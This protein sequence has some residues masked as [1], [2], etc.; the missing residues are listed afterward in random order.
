MGEYSKIEWTDLLLIRGLAV[1][2]YR[3]VATIVM[4]R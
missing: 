2:M 1:S 4:P 3:R